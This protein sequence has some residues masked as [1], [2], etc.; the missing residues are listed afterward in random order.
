MRPILTRALSLAAENRRL[1]DDCERL[2]TALALANDSTDKALMD[3]RRVEQERD[4][5]QRLVRALMESAPSDLRE[6]DA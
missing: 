1:R 4:G 2:L 3:L 6:L 5:Y